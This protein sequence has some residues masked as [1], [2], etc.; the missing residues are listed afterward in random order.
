[1]EYLQ[2]TGETTLKAADFDFAAP[3]GSTC[4]GLR[5]CGTGAARTDLEKEDCQSKVQELH[6]QNGAEVGI[7][8]IQA[9]NGHLEDAVSTVEGTDLAVVGTNPEKSLKTKRKRAD[10]KTVQTRKR[11]KGSERRNQGD[12][13]SKRQR[14]LSNTRETKCAQNKRVRRQ[15]DARGADSQG[16]GALG[17]DPAGAGRALSAMPRARLSS[18]AGSHW[19]LGCLPKQ[20]PCSSGTPAARP[21]EGSST[22]ETGK[23]PGPGD[24]GEQHAKPEPELDAEPWDRTSSTAA[25]ISPGACCE[26]RRWC[27][28]SPS[29]RPPLAL[30][31]TCSASAQ[32]ALTS[33][34]HLY[35]TASKLMQAYSKLKLTVPS[36]KLYS[37]RQY[38][39]R[40]K[41]YTCVLYMRRIPSVCITL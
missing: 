40:F 21:E 7:Q 28:P 14:R 3:R 23:V 38:L 34:S 26:S 4:P 2:K 30:E 32:S 31:A 39:R 22:L 27:Q 19:E 33:R 8:N 15:T 20:G 12:P 24:L 41:V 9:G 13:K 25:T 11:E 6:A 29:A 36:S 17:A 35:P 18:A 10:G 37:V 5:G 16:V 1:M